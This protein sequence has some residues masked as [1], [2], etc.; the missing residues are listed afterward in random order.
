M[1][2]GREEGVGEVGSD[3]EEGEGEEEGG[4]GV[5]AGGGAGG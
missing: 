4:G 1:E 3:A 5:V 2:G